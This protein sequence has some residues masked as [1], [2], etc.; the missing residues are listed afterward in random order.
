MLVRIPA[1][2]WVML[3]RITAL[4]WVILV[5]I[6]P[7]KVGHAGENTWVMLVGNDMWCRG[8]HPTIL[9]AA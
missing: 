9:T 7:P 8:L 6:P 1:I 2:G 3:A 5:R 4:G